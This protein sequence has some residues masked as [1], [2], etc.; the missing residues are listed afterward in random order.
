[1]I[2]AEFDSKKIER[3]FKEDRTGK[4]ELYIRDIFCDDNKKKELRKLLS[5]QFNELSPEDLAGAGNL[6]HL[7]YKIHF[8]INTKSAEQKTLSFGRIARW[9]LSIAGAIL[10][11]FVVFTGIKNKRETSL[12]KETW[13]EIKAPAW[14][15]AQFCLPDGSSGWL[16]SNS[17]I[18][19]N[20]NFN[21]DRK[22]TLAGEA[23][24]DVKSDKSRPFAVY[25]ADVNVKVLGTRFNIASYDDE[26]TVEVVLEEGKLVFT[27]NDMINT[28]TLKPG[29]LVVYNKILNNCTTSVVQSQ[30]YT[31]WTD[32]KLVFRNDPLDVIARRLA[33]WYNVDIELNV[34]KPEDFRWRATFVDDNLE[35]VL[36][37]LKRSLHVN[38]S[39]E[40]R[41]IKPDDTFPK[42]KVIL[43]LKN[44]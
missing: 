43:S 39:I 20:G 9:A 2:G 8:D 35:E 22:I 3:Y 31:S 30:K 23:F 38:Y 13:V 15:R 18:K 34:S 19:Y 4:D 28:Y 26:N 6:D 5:R 10:I 40:N 44:K 32:G 12:A 25:T 33:R 1:M 41:Q 21:R 36:L 42:K 11:P 24:F 29:D 17:S 27:D 37:M 14:T 16:N 7:L